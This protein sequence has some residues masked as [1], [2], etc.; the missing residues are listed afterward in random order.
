MKVDVTCQTV[1]VMET[2]FPFFF[3]RRENID[4]SNSLSWQ[5]AFRKFRVVELVASCV[6]VRAARVFDRQ[7]LLQPLQVRGD[8]RAI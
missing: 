6:G 1:L 4:F 8:A 5:E 7:V 3:F 2:F